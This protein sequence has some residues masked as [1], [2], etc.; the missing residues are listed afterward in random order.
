MVSGPA[1]YAGWV[2]AVELT[3]PVVATRRS[4]GLPLQLAHL[5]ERLGCWSSWCSANRSLRSPSASG[6]GLSPA[7]VLAAVTVVLVGEA[8][9]GLAKQRRGTLTTGAPEE[10]P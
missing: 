5:P 6:G 2:V 10:R 3:A 1:R 4:A 7:A 9:A 8:V